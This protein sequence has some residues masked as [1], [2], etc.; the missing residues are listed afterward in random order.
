MKNKKLNMNKKMKSNFTFK[1]KYIK[2]KI[3]LDKFED[4]TN[5]NEFLMREKMF[6][7][8]LYS[9]KEKMMKS[10]NDEIF[11]KMQ[12]KP[13]IDEK[14]R[15]IMND[16]N[17]R[18]K[19]IKQNNSTSRINNKRQ[20]M[21][22]ENCNSDKNF[23]TNNNNIKTIVNN[24]NRNN[25]KRKYTFEKLKAKKNL[26]IN[27]I[28]KEANDIKRTN[29]EN[30][31]KIKRNQK[32]ELYTS[33]INK[34]I[35]KSKSSK[36][37]YMDRIKTKSDYDTIIKYNAF[38]AS[39][40]MKK[41]EILKI[42][43]Q[44]NNLC[45]KE[46][47]FYSF[48]QLLFDFGFVN[49]KHQEKYILKYDEIDNNDE[50]IDN[51]LI[52][53]YFDENLIAK[54]FIFNEINIIKNAFKSINENFIVQ[55]YETDNL[56]N[57]KNIEAILS[58]INF[59]ISIHQFKLFVYI[60]TN[61][62]DGIDAEN[63]IKIN[64]REK[65]IKDIQKHLEDKNNVN[66]KKSE[67]IK[68]EKLYIFELIRKIVL[69]KN[70]DKFTTDYINNYKIHF[71][72]MINNYEKFKILSEVQNKEK[73]NKQ[74]EVFR[75]HTEYSFKP[76]VNKSKSINYFKDKL[77]NTKK[78]KENNFYKN[79][80]LKNYELSKEKKLTF[81]PK[82]ESPN[83][84]KIF[85]KSLKNNTSVRNK[86]KKFDNILHNLKV[87]V[88]TIKE[89]NKENTKV[90]NITNNPKKDN[91]EFLVTF[92]PEKLIKEKSEN[93]KI[94]SKPKTKIN[95][96]N[97]NEKI[98]SNRTKKNNIKSVIMLNI[99]NAKKNSLLVIDPNDDYKEV[100]NKFCIE[101]EFQSEQYMKILQA[102]R[103]KINQNN[104]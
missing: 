10:I 51:L 87:K 46:I 83:L 99:K 8:K 59:S 82:I 23:K 27:N 48:C 5:F 73:T 79:Q 11:S 70:L 62:F 76:R 6:E 49:I 44:I 78:N 97:Q 35:K 41:I 86:A 84:K 43:E 65:S 80:S 85:E 16:K 100:I 36:L 67:E 75:N 54:E 95:N 58:D 13:N 39:V 34:F 63:I 32:M 30:N 20:L 26:T 92:N 89:I 88:N 77:D 25:I 57:N 28:D 102:V 40:K 71:N 50:I 15:K 31:I 37:I 24:G 19:R 81:K 42:N 98:N 18:Q 22:L 101:N 14:S 96:K 3:N 7:Y 12:T 1:N 60:I 69:V 45:D 74:K 9:N 33:K 53:A 90:N 104:F 93:I 21:K 94:K 68:N 66:V 55:K 38:S 56:E 2:E 64:D 4:N 72:Y 61:L 29:S 103:Y 91:N 47:N 17:K 52:R